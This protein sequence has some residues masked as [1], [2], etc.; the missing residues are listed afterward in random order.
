MSISTETLNQPLH[1][2]KARPVHFVGVGG[3]GMSGLAKVLIQSGFQV[4]GSD[5]S[6]SA[7]TEEL[8]ALGGHIFIGHA[9][10]QVP[11]S[12][13][14]IV[15]S[16]IDNQNP[17]IAL[18]LEQG[19]EIHHRSCLLREVMQGALLGHKTTIGITG[20][21]G[22]TSITGMTGLA[23]KLAGLDP[24]VVVG[25]KMP[26]L[27]TNAL[28]SPNQQ[29][30]VAELD[31]SDGTI[32]QYQPSVSVVANLELD[33]AD[34]YTNGLE[35]VLDT[36]RTYLKA[37]KPGSKV[38]YNVTCPNT[39]RLMADSPPGLESILIAPGDV[40]TGQE[41][42]TT[43]WLKNARPY[44]KGCYQGYVYRNTKMLGELNMSVP[45]LHNL[46]NGLCAVAVGDQLGAD[47]DLLAEAL[48]AFTGMGRRFE[49]VGERNHTLLVDDYAH[50]PSEVLVTLKAAKES[51]QGTSGRVIAVF[52]PHRYSRLQALWEEFLTC[53]EDADLLYLTDVYAAHEP[54]IPGMTA[55]AFAQAVKHPNAHYVPL[56]ADFGALRAALQAEM[57][58]GDIVLS[59]GAGNITK[60]LRNWSAE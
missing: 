56:T 35:G 36:F 11:K 39:Q 12:A 9:A 28:L 46:F 6:A 4:S 27:N 52:Q 50:H 10:S 7:Y 25:G 19:L 58:P 48:Q 20:T 2:D 18:A 43:Y 17:E 42:Q 21:H 54:V 41:Q 55:D 22:K 15:S 13:M 53:F 49:K 26:R 51:L 38:L 8:Q 34:H 14:L 60:L 40:F 31:E 47:F 5:L 3:V 57:R 30:A 16:S 29:Y 1:L 24:T 23:L 59:M 37:L 33:H 32:V 45:G 44:S